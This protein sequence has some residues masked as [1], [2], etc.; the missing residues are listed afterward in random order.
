[1][2]I[3]WLFALIIYLIIYMKK[4]RCRK[5]DKKINSKLKACPYC[6]KKVK[7]KKDK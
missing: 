1:M 2:L 3:V 4:S 5:C 6:W 7:I